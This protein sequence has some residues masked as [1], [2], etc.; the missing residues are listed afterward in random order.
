MKI[1]QLI[2]DGKVVNETVVAM[3]KTPEEAKNLA[4]SIGFTFGI[5]YDGFSICD[6][7]MAETVRRG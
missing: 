5:S 7:W 6:D 3:P 1:L 2:K 4:Y